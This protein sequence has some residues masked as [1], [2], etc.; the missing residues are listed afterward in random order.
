MVTRRGGAWQSAL[1]T[2]QSANGKTKLPATSF[3]LPAKDN[4]NSWSTSG[5]AALLLPEQNVALR[6]EQNLWIGP[7]DA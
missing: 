5:L 4:A 7:C 2:Q 6:M 1:G 3:Q